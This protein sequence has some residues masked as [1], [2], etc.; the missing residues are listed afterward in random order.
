MDKD[1]AGVL[2]YLSCVY[3]FSF[4]N[5]AS[6]G[7][8]FGLCCF[9]TINKDTKSETKQIYKY[10]HNKKKNIKEKLTNNKNTIFH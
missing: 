3:S 2:D 6:H 1:S 9:F 7:V 5:L 10:T 8:N 4:S